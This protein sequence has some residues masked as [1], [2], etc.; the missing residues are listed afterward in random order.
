MPLLMPKAFSN[1]GLRSQLHAEAALD[2][3]HA[4]VPFFPSKETFVRGAASPLS[5]NSG[6]DRSEPSVPEMVYRDSFWRRKVLE[7]APQERLL[8]QNN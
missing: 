8:P 6:R 4:R 3:S 7:H 1:D 2:Q 5:A